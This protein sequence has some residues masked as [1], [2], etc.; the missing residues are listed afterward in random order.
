M[1]ELNDL[2]MNIKEILQ[3]TNG[4]KIIEWLE[5]QRDGRD[6]ILHLN[7]NG[8]VE[9]IGIRTIKK[10]EEI[11]TLNKIINSLTNLKEYKEN[12]NG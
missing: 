2:E 3:S 1:R 7:P 4:G 10:Y 11:N 12:N 5:T 6:R 9:E 8:S